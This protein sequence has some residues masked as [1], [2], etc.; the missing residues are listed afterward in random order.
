MLPPSSAEQDYGIVRKRKT[1]G[2]LAPSKAAY[3]VNSWSMFE[4][5]NVAD[6]I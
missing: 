5:P 6:L 2:L 1:W 3:C 4:N